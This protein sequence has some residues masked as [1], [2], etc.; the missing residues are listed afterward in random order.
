VSRH[1]H[2][3]VAAACAVAAVIVPG[4]AAACGGCFSPPP[5]SPERSQVVT[6][7]RMVLS[8]S[9]RET[10]LWDQIRYAGSPDEFVWV[11]P[12]ADAATARIGLADDNFVEA[13][14]SYTA[15]TISASPPY[16]TGPGGRPAASTAPALGMLVGCGAGPADGLP[17]GS[18]SESTHIA[19]GGE[20]VVGPYDIAVISTKSGDLQLDAWLRRNGY[21]IPP[22]TQSVIDHYVSL[23]FDFIV[24][25]LAPGEGVQQM[26]PVRITTRGYSPVLP[27]QMV[28]AGVGDKVA[29]TLMVLA[30]SRMEAGGFGNAVIDEGALVFDYAAMRS[31]W[32]TL[33]DRAMAGDRRGVWVTES[34]Q[35]ILRDALSYPI[36]WQTPHA[37]PDAGPETDAGGLD[38]DAL[39]VPD[40]FAP[41]TE[42]GVSV[43][44]GGSMA[45]VLDDAGAMA[46]AAD[47]YV[48]RRVAFEGL[49]D[50]A[51]VTRLRSELTALRLDHD[52]V[53]NASD[54]P[55]VPVQYVAPGL[56]NAP[57]CPQYN[58][59]STVGTVTPAGLEVLA[60]VGFVARVRRRRKRAE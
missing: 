38:I 47:P 8:L 19:R 57:T 59:C 39:D 25:R 33:F 46:P 4:I 54:G 30:D 56:V 21:A 15:P 22:A 13:L 14:D 28:A 51:V 18:G 43:M 40:P 2:G 9:E 16:C 1:L 52:L 48:D 20:A 24:L 3:A 50:Q 55:L 41:S 31:N 32:N 44:D 23:E 11:L 17:P 6:D 10:T 45:M 29:L 58:A 27:L 42:G 53:L 5:P 12:I 49:G 35:N 34:A 26:Q 7:H 60:V 36:G 37:G